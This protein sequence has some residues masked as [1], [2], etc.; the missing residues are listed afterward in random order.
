M[1]QECYLQK[2]Y[3]QTILYRLINGEYA[4]HW[5]LIKINVPNIK[6]NV[7]SLEYSE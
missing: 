3:F 1:P 5:K 2:E 6:T 4:D 7:Y